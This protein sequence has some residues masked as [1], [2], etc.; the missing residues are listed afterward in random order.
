M[1]FLKPLV[2]FWSVLTGTV[3]PLDKNILHENPHRLNLDYPPPAFIGDIRRARIIVLKKCGGY[4]RE[5]VEEE[6]NDPARPD[7]YRE[8]L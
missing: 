1:L 7:L 3:H 5:R 6:F 8:C 4:N 2:D